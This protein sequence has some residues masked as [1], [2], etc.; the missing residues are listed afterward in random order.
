MG[1]P[2]GELLRS[3]SS[4]LIREW[5]F[6]SNGNQLAVHFGE[7]GV[8]GNFILYD[9]ASGKQVE[10]VSGVSEPSGLPQWAKSQSQLEDESVVEGPA[11]AQQRTA[12]IAKV[13]KRLKGIQ[14]G[15]TRKDLDRLL[16]TEGGLST[17]LQRTPGWTGESQEERY[18]R[19]FIAMADRGLFS[20]DIDSYLGPNT[21]YF[22]VALPVSPLCFS[23]LP[24]R[25]RDVL[26]R[27][28]IKGPLL[29]DRLRIPYEETLA[30]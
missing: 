21:A 6:W 30:L 7:K 8:S 18:L 19:S 14:P 11:Y 10:K 29:R 17:R 2:T 9:L 15:M 24:D 22:R 26:G 4:D 25:I 23:D 3:S 28:I 16:T 13:L 27:T 5:H 12:W 20:F 1:S